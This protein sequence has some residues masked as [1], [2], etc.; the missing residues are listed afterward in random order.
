M[1][2]Y[3]QDHRNQKGWNDMKLGTRLLLATLFV[4]PMIAAPA[5]RAQTNT[6]VQKKAATPE[7]DA[8]KKNTD[9]YIALL[10]R[11]VRQ[12][13]AEV[14]GSMMVMSAQDS[15]KFWPIYSEYDVALN[16]LNDQRIATIKEY[17]ENY[18]QMTD[19]KADELVRKSMEFRKQRA[20]LLAGTYEKVKQALGAIT[21]AR[22]VVVEDQLL[23]LIDL[24]IVSSLPIVGQGS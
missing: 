22:F 17:A 13:K 8:K 16:K 3:G 10:R 1:F 9:A 5:G 15:A 18:N 19:E 24:Q 21:A 4:L 6:Q 7:A 20:E 12:E 11:D 23:L 2:G 14:M